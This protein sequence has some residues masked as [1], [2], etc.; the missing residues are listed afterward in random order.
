MLARF[1]RVGGVAH[2]RSLVQPARRLLPAPAG[3][4]QVPAGELRLTVDELIG[5]A[6]SGHWTKMST[7]GRIWAQIRSTSWTGCSVKAL[8]RVKSSS[9]VPYSTAGYAVW[10]N[11]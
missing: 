5:L 9:R 6:G 10:V 2:E 1:D 8:T 7:D 3:R 11:R 4:D